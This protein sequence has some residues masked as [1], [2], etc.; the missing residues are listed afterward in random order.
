MAK[1]FQKSLD[2][3]TLLN[4]DITSIYI[5]HTK[6]VRYTSL[7]KYHKYSL[8]IMQSHHLL[9]QKSFSL[10]IPGRLDARASARDRPMVRQDRVHVL[11]SSKIAAPRHLQGLQR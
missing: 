7:G 6:F 2:L 1:S 8:K 11:Q 5:Y 3:V 10:L 9:M 4:C